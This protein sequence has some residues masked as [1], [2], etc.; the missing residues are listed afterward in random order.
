MPIMTKIT[1]LNHLLRIF[2]DNLRPPPRLNLHEW[3]DKHRILTSKSSGTPGPYSTALFPFLREIMWELSPQSLAEIVVALKGSQLGFTDLSINR[4]LYNMFCRP[5]PHGYVQKTVDAVEKF[6]KQRLQDAIDLIPAIGEKLKLGEKNSS[7]TIKVKS[8]PGGILFLIGANSA[9]ALKSVPMSDVD[10]DEYD[11]Y[12]DDVQDEGDPFW[13]AVRR[14]ANFEGSKIFVYGTPTSARTSK[15]AKKYLDGDQRI[16]HIICPGSECKHTAP[17]IFKHSYYKKEEMPW[18]DPVV[19]EDC[20]E[21]VYENVGKT[22]LSVHLVCPKCGLLINEKQKGH[23]L[24]EE[25]GA[26]WHKYNPD[27]RMPSFFISALYSPKYKWRDAIEMYLEAIL[28]N[29]QNIL[30]VFINTVLG[31]PFSEASEAVHAAGLLGR[32]E[33]YGCEVPAGVLAITIA[34]DIQKNRIEAEAV[35]WGVGEESWSIDY[36][37]FMGDTEHDVSWQQLDL[38]I[39]QGFKKAD[40]TIILPICTLVDAN[41]RRNKA[42]LF[43]RDREVWNVYPIRGVPGWGKGLVKRPK[44]RNDNGVWK[45]ELYVDEIKAKLMSMLQ[46]QEIGPKYCHFPDKPVYNEEYFDMLT[47]EELKKTL[48]NKGPQY[49]WE[50]KKKGMRNEALDIRVYNIAAI[51]IISPNFEAVKNQGQV[52]SNKSLFNQQFGDRKKKSNRSRGSSGL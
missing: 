28:D 27:A 5:V 2:V 31:E 7:D 23:I 41:Y 46:T 33:N 40:G 26:H 13:L 14:T 15:T 21:M 34:T 30:K 3:S 36:R 32:K 37:V 17:I 29:D 42:E 50:L 38:F 19:I 11:T 35:G 18:W 39:K 20:F 4:I 9:T 47:A 49:S 12:D 51:Q 1:A 24:S 48:K 43:C 52:I 8:Y 45:F 25:N 6:S 16:Y 44:K 10:L 22:C